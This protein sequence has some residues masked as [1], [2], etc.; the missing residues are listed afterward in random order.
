MPRRESRI[1]AC[2][3]TTPAGAR[4]ARV[5]EVLMTGVGDGLGGLGLS[6]TRTVRAA[7]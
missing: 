4:S 3:P 7:A 5:W 6:L 2:R 1:R